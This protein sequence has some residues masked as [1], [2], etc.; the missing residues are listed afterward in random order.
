[1]SPIAHSGM[2][3]LGWQ[4]AARRKNLLTFAIFLAAANLPDID[5]LARFVFGP[6]G[7]SLH[8][9][10]THNVLFVGLSTALLSLL[11]PP[12]SDRWGLLL[13]G[14]SHLVLDIIMIDLVRP[15]GIRAFYPFSGALFN[16]GFF[17]YLE[18]GSLKA[19]AS[20]RNLEVMALETAVF[21]LPVVV[22][23]RKRLVREI[24]SRAFWSVRRPA[25]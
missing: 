7:I 17:P 21:V 14:F 16:F 11:L 12:G 5:F 8:Q 15:V 2:A 23:F 9:Y 10:Y 6:T 19:M 22:A 13:V 1:M 20:L 3:L 18:R 4:L 24:G 25:S